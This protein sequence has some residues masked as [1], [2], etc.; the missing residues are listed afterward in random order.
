MQF[1]CDAQKEWHVEGVVMRV[2]R[3]GVRTTCFSVQNW[4]L[5]FNKTFC[6]QCFAKRRN[7]GVA[8]GKG[9]ASFIVRNEVG[10]ALAVASVGVGETVPFVGKRAHCFSEQYKFVDLDRQLALACGHY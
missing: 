6:R 7:D 9:T 2:K 1:K 4:G 5:Y 3:A 10:I 8:N